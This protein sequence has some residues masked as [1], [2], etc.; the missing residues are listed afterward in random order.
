MNKIR[1]EVFPNSDEDVG[2]WY[3]I[4][5]SVKFYLGGEWH[6]TKKEAE[7]YAREFAAKC[8]RDEIAAKIDEKEI[9]HQVFK[10]LEN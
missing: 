3:S 8:E 5:E 2:G 1:W 9:P 7:K 4:I 6:P 10:F